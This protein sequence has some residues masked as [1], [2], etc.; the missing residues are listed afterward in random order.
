MALLFVVLQGLSTPPLVD[1]KPLNIEETRNPVLESAEHV[2]QVSR[3]VFA[4]YYHQ[5]NAFS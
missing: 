2:Y 1:E 3:G 5:N 4:A